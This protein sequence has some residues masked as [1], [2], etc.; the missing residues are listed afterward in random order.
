MLSPEISQI[1]FFISNRSPLITRTDHLLRR[2]HPLN[3]RPSVSS[4]TSPSP[5]TMSSY[6]EPQGWQA[7]AAGARQVSWEQPAPPSRSG[8]GFP[9][10]VGSDNANAHPIWFQA[11]AR[12]PSVRTVRP[13]P[14]NLT[15]RI[16]CFF[17]SSVFPFRRAPLRGGQKNSKYRSTRGTIVE[18]YDSVISATFFGGFDR[19]DGIG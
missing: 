2:F 19:I 7:P 8:M 4:K 10:R 11:R 5:T 13:F 14:P 16:I 1:F 17:R 9:C 18:D 15:V 6:Y 3:R 12:S